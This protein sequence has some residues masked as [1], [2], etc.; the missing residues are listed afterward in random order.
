M[1]MLRTVALKLT[2]NSK[3]MANHLRIL[4]NKVIKAF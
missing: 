2:L 1:G 3:A 4:D